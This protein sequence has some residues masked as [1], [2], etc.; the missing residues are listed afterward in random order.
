MPTG[1][2]AL[3]DT[4]LCPTDSNGICKVETRELFFALRDKETTVFRIG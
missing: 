4:E 2:Y 3:V 1:Y